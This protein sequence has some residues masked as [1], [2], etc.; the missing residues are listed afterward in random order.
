MLSFINLNIIKIKKRVHMTPISSS[1]TI[2]NVTI[3]PLRKYFINKPSS[4]VCSLFHKIYSAGNYVFQKTIPLKY[5]VEP[6]K[7]FIYL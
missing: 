4:I 1:N 6:G 3:N 7:L 2:N 5:K